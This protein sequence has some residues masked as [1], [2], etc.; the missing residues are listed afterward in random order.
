MNNTQ[1]KNHKVKDYEGESFDYQDW[2]EQMPEIM[3]SAMGSNVINKSIY[4]GEE[5]QGRVSADASWTITLDRDHM[6]R[7]KLEGRADEVLNASA[8]AE[9]E[10]DWIAVRED[11]MGKITE[12]IK[13]NV[14]GVVEVSEDEGEQDRWCED[15]PMLI[16]A[17]F[18]VTP[19]AT[20]GDVED[21]VRPFFD[22]MKKITTPD[23]PE[24]DY[25]FGRVVIGR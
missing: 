21:V 5:Y 25:I 3:N 16:F 15:M 13:S 23:A 2:K 20:M 17:V 9:G 12:H 6:D 1:I 7:L 24:S 4:I 11:V 19:D 10:D 18:T 14:P 8:F 22:Y